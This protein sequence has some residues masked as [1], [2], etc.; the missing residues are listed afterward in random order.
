MTWK[1]AVVIASILLALLVGLAVYSVQ[2][3]F[4][5][6]FPVTNGTLISPH[7]LA[8]VTVIRDSNGVPHIFA[9]SDRDAYYALGFVHSQD[10][11]LQMEFLRRYAGGE[12]AEM[13]GESS[14]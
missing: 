14:Q 11:R 7:L 8:P 1:R 2:S 6:P 5:F 10:R 4:K 9:N 12:A 13:G 3:I